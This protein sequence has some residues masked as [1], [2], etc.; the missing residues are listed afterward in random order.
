MDIDCHLLGDGPLRKQLEGTVATLGLSERV[1]FHRAKLQSELGDWY[2]AADLVVLPSLA[3]GIPNVIIE[4]IA[5]RVPFVAS[6]VGGIAEVT[7]IDY[8]CRLV[9]AGDAA[10]LASAISAVL[11]HEAA[12]RFTGGPLRSHKQAAVELAGYFE[13]VREQWFSARPTTSMTNHERYT[14]SHS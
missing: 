8:P 11:G 12:M 6:A 7:P 10:A 9:P 14:L 5:C 2:R 1:Y 3:E 13:T 4:A